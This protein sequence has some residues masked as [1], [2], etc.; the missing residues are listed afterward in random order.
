MSARWQQWVKESLSSDER[1]AARS[2][3]ALALRVMG[4]VLGGFCIAAGLGSLRPMS[5]LLGLAAGSMG[6]LGIRLERGACPRGLSHAMLVILSLVFMLCPIWDG[7]LYS[8]SLYLVPVLPVLGFFVLGRRVGII[9]AGAAL[10]VT[11]GVPIYFGVVVRPAPFLGQTEVWLPVRLVALG[12][13]TCFGVLSAA[14]SERHVYRIERSRRELKMQVER[15]HQAHQAKREFLATM[16]HEIRTPMNGVL[17]MTQ[18]L[19]RSKS[20]PNR[21]MAGRMHL[22]SERLLSLLNRVLELAKIESVQFEQAGE[23]CDLHQLLVEIKKA[24]LAAASDKNI[25]F[26]LE[27]DLPA[28]SAHVAKAHLERAIGLLVDNAIEHSHARRIE[29]ALRQDPASPDE[30]VLSVKDDGQGLSQ[31]LREQIENVI[32]RGH[33]LI[34]GKGDGTGLSIVVA[35]RLLYASGVKLLLDAGPGCGWTLRVPKQTATPAKPVDSI[36]TPRPDPQARAR[37]TKLNIYIAITFVFGIAYLVQSVLTARHWGAFV[38]CGL[39]FALVTAFVLNRSERRNRLASWIFL[40]GVAFDNIGASFADG[41]LHSA[42]LWLIPT[43]P[44]IAA[45][46]LGMRASVYSGIV[47]ALGI[48]AVCLVARHWWFEP[49]FKDASGQL[50]VFRVVLLVLFSSLA[51]VADTISRKLA[52]ILTSQHQDLGAAQKDAESADEETTRFLDAMSRKIGEPMREILNMARVLRKDQVSEDDRGMLDTITRSGRHLLVL[53]NETM[54]ISRAESSIVELQD[55]SFCL[56]ELVGDVERL[57]SPKAELSGLSLITVVPDERIEVVADVTKVLQILCNLVG[58]AIKFSHQGTITVV[59]EAPGQIGPQGVPGRMVS[60][61]VQDQG[62]GIGKE[63]QH[64]IFDDYVQ[65]GASYSKSAEGGTGLG[66]SICSKLA[67][68]MGGEIE[69]HSEVGQGARFTL[70]VWLPNASELESRV[71]MSGA[72]VGPTV[73]VV[74]DNAVNRKVAQA[75]I[76]ALGV[77]VRLASSGAQAIG[78]AREEYF[79]LVLMDLRMPGLSGFE[80][81]ERLQDTARPPGHIAALS[82]DYDSEDFKQLSALAV[83]DCLVKPLRQEELRGALAKAGLV[84]QK[85]A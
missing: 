11:L 28:C 6:F 76:E 16:S 23:D 48:S 44:L 66:L 33:H 19:A 34:E 22:W 62:I 57:F 63:Q 74:D 20:L 70:K 39:V 85:A 24:K 2:R 78:L 51:V 3:L 1:V 32:E 61:S 30:L 55:Q 9:Y 10:A 29:L 36:D 5:L 4:A 59:L 46:I 40:A 18:L 52:D 64:K 68:I 14:L 71:E 13:M 73:L 43:C 35:H 25:E 38:G 37:Q 26:D 84:E 41:Q 79:E 21:E 58:N 67:T 53:M 60:L 50:A 69:L 45:T 77:R 31:R 47:S 15:V 49:E 72:S 83:E 65:L 75:S 54:D 7:Q 42:T 12:L 8:L 56:N 80:T 17:G 82:A 81:I 27:L